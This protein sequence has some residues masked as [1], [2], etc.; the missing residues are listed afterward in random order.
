MKKLAI[1]FVLF[2]GCAS[3]VESTRGLNYQNY[4]AANQLSDMVKSGSLD[5]SKVDSIA[6]NIMENSESIAEDIGEPE[7]PKEF[8]PQFSADLRKSQKEELS[9]AGFF[10]GVLGLV[11]SAGEN[12]VSSSDPTTKIVGLGILGLLGLLGLSKY[13]KKSSK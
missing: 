8:S 11:Q 4:S 10:S 3:V 13:R 5:P 2:C 6:V 1:V 9:S 12:M 7:D